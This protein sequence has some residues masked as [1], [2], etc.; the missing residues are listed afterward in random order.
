MHT[1]DYTA[2]VMDHFH[3][4]RNVG[5]LKDADAKTTV[6][7]PRCGDFIQVWIKV[8]DETIVDY[9][10]KVFGCGAA[11]ATTSVL[12]ELAIGK[13]FAEVSEITDDDVI[14]ALGGLPS[15]KKHC[16]LLAVQ[17]LHS[18]V[19]IYLVQ[20]N[21]KKYQARLDQYRQLGCDFIQERANLVQRL[22]NLPQDAKILD[23]GTGKGYTAIQLALAGYSCTSLDISREEQHFALLN[24]MYFHVDDR[25]DFQLESIRDSSFEDESFDA[26]ISVTTLHHI[27]Q[28][29]QVL[30]EIFRICKP[31]GTILVADFNQA[32]LRIVSQM[33]ASEGK[34][35]Q[36]IGWSSAQIEEWLQARIRR[37]EKGSEG[38]L[39]Y[40]KTL[41][42]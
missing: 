4:P 11:I 22:G 24:A 25:I 9:K 17:G 7:D 28:T 33:H 23:V 42:E 19:A 2:Q 21:H 40:L 35:H 31:G 14:N 37:F 1:L 39:W 10:Y 16:S 34:E 18:A 41:K 15:N 3:N 36:A 5:E 20:E 12:S 8:K 38:C 13:S 6:G 27:E 30:S 26:V 29:D 32:G